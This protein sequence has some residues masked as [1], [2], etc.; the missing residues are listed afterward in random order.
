[1]ADTLNLDTD[2]EETC[3]ARVWE[4]LHFEKFRAQIERET[5]GTLTG[6]FFQPG[7]NF[8]VSGELFMMHN[9]AEAWGSCT[10]G[11]QFLSVQPFSA[12]A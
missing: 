8:F 9:L 10:D 3:K 4:A 7:E 12:A 1:M 11:R 2:V 6:Q 5:D